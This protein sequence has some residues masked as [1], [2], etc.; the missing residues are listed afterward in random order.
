M[1]NE[2]VSKEGIHEYWEAREKE[3]AIEWIAYVCHQANK[4]WCESQ[5]DYSQKDW[6][7]AEQ[8]Q[9]D[10]AVNGVKFRLE[11]PDAPASAQ[12]ESWMEEKLSQGWVYGEVKDAE[13][14]T[15]PC[16]VPFEELPK[17]QQKKDKLFSAIVDALK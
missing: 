15:H 16:I 11:N 12:H 10:S 2:Q 9:R 13:K 1:D 17:F 6:A 3:V 14:K 7:E 4:A 8:W 5:G